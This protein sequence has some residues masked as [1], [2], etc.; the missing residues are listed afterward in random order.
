LGHS[1]ISRRGPT[2]NRQNGQDQKKGCCSHGS[3]LSRRASR[4]TMARAHTLPLH[5][6]VVAPGGFFTF[7]NADRRETEQALE[8]NASRDRSLRTKP[9]IRPPSR[10]APDNA[11]AFTD[12]G[13]RRPSVAVL[14]GCAAGVLRCRPAAAM[15]PRP[16]TP[17]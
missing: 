9:P 10:N 6:A 11:A 1:G 13:A 8:T 5:D 7:R 16:A 2:R 12:P 4:W 17:E 3:L 15:P 14:A